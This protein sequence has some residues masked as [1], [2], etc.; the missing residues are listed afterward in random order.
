MQID[1]KQGVSIG[2]PAQRQEL[3]SPGNR[4]PE[5]WRIGG[6]AIA[7]LARFELQAEK[8]SRLI[9]QEGP[10][11]LYRQEEVADPKA[12]AARPRDR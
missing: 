3:L 5:E 10:V 11:S 8:V 7:D 9:G 4:R 6:E 1:R 2:A 12:P